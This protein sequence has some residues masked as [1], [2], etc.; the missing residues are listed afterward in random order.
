[1]RRGERRGCGGKEEGNLN[2]SPAPPTRVFYRGLDKIVTFPVWHEREMRGFRA[3]TSCRGTFP[4][5]LLKST[6]RLSPRGCSCLWPGWG[7]LQNLGIPSKDASVT[8]RD[9][10]NLLANLSP[11]SRDRIHENLQYDAYSLFKTALLNTLEEFTMAMEE[12]IRHLIPGNR[13]K[14]GVN[15]KG[16]RNNNSDIKLKYSWRFYLRFNQSI[17]PQ[18]NIFQTYFLLLEQLK[19]L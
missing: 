2:S 17:K 15:Q 4:L 7:S 9:G 1:M 6:R 3:K 13:F 18:R 14:W 11:T 16:E 5:D 8:T 12:W 10:T 19:K